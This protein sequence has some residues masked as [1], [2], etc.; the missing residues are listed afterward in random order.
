[1]DYTLAS[2]DRSLEQHRVVSTNSETRVQVRR[3]CLANKSTHRGS[4]HPPPPRLLH[5]SPRLL[6]S[7]SAPLEASSNL[8]KLASCSALC[9][10]DTPMATGVLL[11]PHANPVPN[12]DETAG[13]GGAAN[14]PAT[15]VS[16]LNPSFWIER[17]RLRRPRFQSSPPWTA[18]P[19]DLAPPHP[20]SLI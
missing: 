19:P 9:P 2:S 3:T 11:R 16:S 8:P 7:P 20:P 10:E 1:M 12:L 18:L 15:F 4:C 6:R 13:G 14:P 17:R 5:A